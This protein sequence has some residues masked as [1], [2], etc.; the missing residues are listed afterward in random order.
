MKKKKGLKSQKRRKLNTGVKR[1][2]KENTLLCEIKIVHSH[3]Q[4]NHLQKVF[5][6]FFQGLVIWMHSRG[7]L[8]M[9]WF[10]AATAP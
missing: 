2:R 3:H 10:G 1:M 5:Q 6:Y 9:C 7:I 4:L 8:R